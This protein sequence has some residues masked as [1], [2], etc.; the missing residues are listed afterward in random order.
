MPEVF[1]GFGRPLLAP[2]AGRIIEVLDGED[3]HVAR[4][5][6]LTLAPYALSQLQ[7]YKRRGKPAIAGNYLIIEVSPMVPT[8]GSCT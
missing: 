5:S 4:R 6:Q 3:D 7:R 2:V 1:P 8:W